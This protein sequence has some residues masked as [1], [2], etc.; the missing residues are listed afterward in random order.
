SAGTG[1]KRLSAVLVTGE[2]AL[3]GVL[4]AGAGVLIRNFLKI[5][6][7]DKGVKTRNLFIP[8]M[9][10]PPSSFF[11]HFMSRPPSLPGVESVASANTLQ[12]S[13][14]QRF[15]Y[16]LAGASPIEEHRRPKTAT[17]IIGPDYFRTLGATVLS[18]RDFK[19]VDGPVV[20]VNQRFA[21][22]SWAGQ[23]PLGK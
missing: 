21:A 11:K 4:L 17:V 8:S 20:L 9:K 14:A 22:Y 5:Y 6:Y 23:D 7:A 3:A 12:A 1:G 2:M 15:S 19:D 13:G 18:G 10:P 16:E